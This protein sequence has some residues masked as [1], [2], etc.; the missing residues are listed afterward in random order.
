MKWYTEKKI[1]YIIQIYYTLYHY[2]CLFKCFCDDAPKFLYHDQQ[3]ALLARDDDTHSMDKL[4]GQTFIYNIKLITFFFRLRAMK[5]QSFFG[6]EA[7]LGGHD[8]YMIDRD[9]A[10]KEMIS[11]GEDVNLDGVDARYINGRETWLDIYLHLYIMM[12]ENK[13]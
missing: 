2:V 7:R 11:H 13:V 8:A 1:K 3:E 10:L 6:Q 4:Q 9:G 12:Q 5:I